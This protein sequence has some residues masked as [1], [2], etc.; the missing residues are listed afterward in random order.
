MEY[1]FSMDAA[2]KARA[3]KKGD[4]KS[5]EFGGEAFDLPVELPFSFSEALAE[6]KWRDAINAVLNGQAERFF[7]VEPPITNEDLVEFATQLSE[8][9][10]GEEPGESSASRSR[11]KPTGKSSRPRSS[12]STT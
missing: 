7:A 1:A 9:Y 12:R 8:L 3:E 11:S 4:P 10:V 2:R 6:G 5:F